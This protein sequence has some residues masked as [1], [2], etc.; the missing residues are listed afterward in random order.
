MPDYHRIAELSEGYPEI[1]L[2]IA[3]NLED[4]DDIPDNILELGDDPLIDRLIGTNEMDRQEEQATKRVLEALSLFEKVEWKTEDGEVSE[5]AKWV[6]EFVGFDSREQD[7]LFREIVKTQ[8]ERG[9]LDGDYYLRVTPLPLATHLLGTWIEKHGKEELEDLFD[10]IPPDMQ[11]RFGIRIPYMSS[12]RAGE[13]WISDKLTYDDTFYRNDG[14]VLKTDWGSQLFRQFAE[15]APR[16]AIQPLE[17]F[18]EARTREDLLQ[19]STGRRNI[20]TS[21]QYIAVWRDTFSRAA[22]L[23]LQ[24]AEAENEEYANNATG[25]FTG[26]FSPGIG[27]LAPTE[28]PPNS[29]VPV[30][31]D[32]LQSDSKRRQEIGVEA[33][34]S[35]LRGQNK[36]TKTVGP[37]YQGARHTPDLWQPDTWQGLFDYYRDVWSLLHDSLTNLDPQQR[38]EGVN[39]LTGSVRELAKLHP[40]ISEEIRE[41]LR[42]L[43]ETDW[44]DDGEIIRATVEL[45]HYEGE[46]LAEVEEERQAW[47][48]FLTQ[49]TEESFQG[50]IQRYIGLSLIADREIIDQK[51]EDIAVEAISNP[52]KLEEQIPWLV[53]AKPNNMRAFELGEELSKLDRHQTH[54]STI[55]SEFREI[56]EDRGIGFISGYLSSL[57]EQDEQRREQ[58][59]DQIQGSDE[60]QPYLM[61][62]IRLSGVTEQDINRIVSLFRT[63]DISGEDLRGFETGGVSRS[64]DSDTFA[65]LTEMIVDS[66]DPQDVLTFLPVLFHYYVFPDNSPPLPEQPTRELL[67]HPAFVE[68]MESVNV[69]QGL[70]HDWKEV[71]VEYLNQNPG[72]AETMLDAAITAFGERESVVGHSI[73]LKELLNYLLAEHPEQ[74]WERI[75]DVLDERDE[76]MIPLQMWLSGEAVH[77]DEIPLKQVPSDWIWDWIEQNVEENA[78]TAAMIVPSNL[79]H[80]DTEVCL[81]RE[82][83]KR[84]G[85]REEVRST[86]T[87]NYG[88][89]SWM[90]PTSEHYDKKKKQLEEFRDQ[91]DNE[92]VLLWVNN[93]IS[94]FEDKISQARKYEERIGYE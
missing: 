58:M 19:F 59:L 9:I 42:D 23:L 52:E 17:H 85:H 35:A 76:R 12:F 45:L 13:N 21:L 60:L 26:L 38:S 22:H 25:I 3:R 77:I 79:Y 92:N 94:E 34:K 51:V 84:Y 2:K 16:E 24:L 7:H 67:T 33:A 6:A 48:D 75:I 73:E 56:G 39:V 69:R 90:G 46:T 91:E 62:I 14:A 64:I 61:D 40:E 11:Q 37:E 50:K 29:R 55:F 49:L 43:S 47:D 1:A 36:I 18:F 78:V 15:A 72:R 63:G 66:E 31:K 20:I 30:L 83:L 93:R 74:T 89:E 86:F 27:K 4:T 88:T 32:V 87:G 54:L 65:D 28:A 5:E 41:T 71:A 70:S 44:V 82:L 10:D 81:G 68:P 8:Q 57:A 80:S 53:T